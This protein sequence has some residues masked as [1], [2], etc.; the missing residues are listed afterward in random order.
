LALGS[1]D[2]KVSLVSRGMGCCWF[3]EIYCSCRG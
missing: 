3:C 2:L 1:L